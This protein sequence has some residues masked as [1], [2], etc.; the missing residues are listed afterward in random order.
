MPLPIQNQEINVLLEHLTTN[1]H[2]VLDK[3]EKLLPRGEFHRNGNYLMVLNL[4]GAAALSL[5][6]FKLAYHYIEQGLKID[7]N[8]HLL[9]TLSSIQRKEGLHQKALDSIEEGLRLDGSHSDHYITKARCLAE[10]GKWDELE[11]FTE[12]FSD[13]NFPN[14]DHLKNFFLGTLN[15]RKGDK[16]LGEEYLKESINF[17]PNIPDAYLEL[18]LLYRSNLNFPAVLETL[19]KLGE[20]KY[21]NEHY[22]VEIGQAYLE[23]GDTEK[24]EE[25]LQKA[26]A[27]NEHNLAANTLLSKIELLRNPEDRGSRLKKILSSE[28]PNSVRAEIFR[29]LGSDQ[30]LFD[31]ECFR[32]LL[33]ALSIERDA[34]K[35]LA[36]DLS[37]IDRLTSA[38]INAGFN[39]SDRGL[40]QDNETKEKRVT[41]IVGLPT[42]ELSFFVYSLDDSMVKVLN[43]E[44]ILTMG[45]HTEK[46][47]PGT[48]WHPHILL[49]LPKLLKS[50]EAANIVFLK[51]HPKDSCIS[52]L[53]TKPEQTCL[54]SPFFSWKNIVDYNTSLLEIWFRVSQGSEIAVEAHL[55]DILNGEL[56][57]REELASWLPLSASAE[58]NL[59]KY[60]AGDWAKISADLAPYNRQ[61]DTFC[62][63]LGY[64]NV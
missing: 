6:D 29:S 44:L 51:Q 48:Y 23:L 31:D 59:S 22:F 39:D 24:S 40:E 60:E 55:E 3:G 38:A 27:I 26:L 10:L 36:T 7:R 50:N 41:F 61:L 45:D 42:Q 18:A 12:I 19:L 5:R 64:I 35:N 34:N 46:L 13:L 1:P 49:A 17:S 54:N 2:A 62:S 56:N 43:E 37:E 21:T 9:N 16:L 52:I 30:T 33:E 15:W 58:S 53:K 47:Q 14:G 8:A 28:P 4:M 11:S 32:Y 25:K 20:E 63:R 57:N